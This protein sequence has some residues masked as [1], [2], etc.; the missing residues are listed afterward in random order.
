MCIELFIKMYDFTSSTNLNTQVLCYMNFL[1]IK[2][3]LLHMVTF[4]LYF[5]L[6]IFESNRCCGVEIKGT[7]ELYFLLLLS[8]CELWSL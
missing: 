8:L 2:E 3:R 6:N 5:S 4:A 7:N 1:E